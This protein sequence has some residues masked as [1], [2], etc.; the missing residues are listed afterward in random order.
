MQEYR[1]FLHPFHRTLNVVSLKQEILIM[2]HFCKKGFTLIELLVVVAIIAVLIAML[3]P[4]LGSARSAARAV[5]CS[6]RMGQLSKAVLMYEM[7]Y[8][9]VPYFHYV[10]SVGGVNKDIYW[11]TKLADRK[12]VV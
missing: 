9:Q 8:R 2:K 12:S 4:A 6:T 11:I 5:V 10:E 3:L 7:E 1:L